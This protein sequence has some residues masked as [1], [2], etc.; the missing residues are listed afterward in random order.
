MLLKSNVSNSLSNGSMCFW[1][2]NDLLH[3]EEIKNQL[4]DFS[5]GRFSGVVIHARAGLRIEYLS[6]EWFDYFE[7]AVEQARQLGIDV[8]IY[9][10]D[11]WPSGFAGGKVNSLGKDYQSKTLFF[12]TEPEDAQNIL[13]AYRITDKGYIRIPSCEVKRGDLICAFKITP[14]YVDLLSYNV[15]KKFIEIT[16]E[17]Y[18]KRMGKYF[19]TV[20]KGVFTDEPQVSNLPYSPAIVNAWKEKY[21][22]DLLDDLY[23][24]A[25][26]DGEYKEFRVRYRKLISELLFNSFTSQISNW[27][28]QNNLLFTGHFATE[29]GLAQ[30]MSSNCGVMYQYTAMSMPGIDHLGKR[31]TSPILCKQVSSVA[32][33][34]GR[35]EILSETFGCSGWQINFNELYW[36][37]GRQNAL[38]ITKPCFHLSAYSMAGRRKRDYPAFFSY[39][40]PWWDE[41][42]KLMENIDGLSEFMKSGES[43]VDWLVISPLSSVMM[44]YKSQESIY[45]SAE[46]RKLVE[47]MLDAQL[48]CDLGDEKIISSLGRV[49]SGYFIVGNARYKN[50]VVSECEKLSED[51]ISLLE[52]F[53]L[54]GGIV[55]FINK[56]PLN[57]EYLN[58]TVICN[59]RE[60]L[61]KVAQKFSLD[62]VFEVCNASSGKIAHNLINR[63]RKTDNGYIT[64]IWSNED[65]AS[66]KYIVKYKCDNFGYTINTV[67][68]ATLERFTQKTYFDGK[69]VCA[70]I[71]LSS[72]A[73]LLLELVQGDIKVEDNVKTEEV[74]DASNIKV[75]LTDKNSITLDYASLSV[76]DG[77][78]GESKSVIHFINKIYNIRKHFDSSRDMNI[79]LKYSF[80]CDE[81]VNLTTL[82]LAVEDENVTDIFVCGQKLEKIRTSWWMDKKIGVYNIGD[83]VKYGQNEI[84]LSYNIPYTD[85]SLK[86]D[87]FESE[88]N[89][90]FFPVEPESIYIRGNF[91]VS[92]NNVLITPYEHIVD[93]KNFTLIPET[94]KT[95]GDLTVQNS[96]FYRGNAKYEFT[97][98]CDCKKDK[99]ILIRTE[100]AKCSCVTVEAN[101]Q[102]ITVINPDAYVDIT[103]ILS[104]GDN[105][106]TV[107]L[108]GTNRN[109][110]GPHHHIKGNPAM[111][112]PDTF[113]GVKGFED[114]VS[115]DVIT[116]NTWTESYNFIP[117]GCDRIKIKKLN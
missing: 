24:L 116:N 88:R 84:V 102:K 77:E 57:C 2:W 49:E 38:G 13:T 5:K 94:K 99:N 101:N 74:Y 61:Q 107:S 98:D 111:V 70:V 31:C 8:W 35:D 10:E 28:E 11:G 103:K 27:C 65:F 21:G 7:Y 50:L 97:V 19:G 36:L 112:G 34:L 4:I 95:L 25:V 44:N 58:G 72:C 68:P 76:E 92:V 32:N 115:P 47:N 43:C 55:W 82:E 90:F 109:L 15:V 9:D 60:L 78:F 86:K 17:E 113:M 45:Y 1:S 85:K 79:R 104:D 59:R 51:M 54:Q 117:F 40:E 29:D 71:E 75:S 52:C 48:D 16:H 67:N 53:V 63:T 62:R 108:I 96:W 110:L 83:L 30:Q 42:P 14:N 18:K 6:D 87:V 26:N 22:T 80:V 37:W 23:M 56:K 91:D 3:K 33:Q 64:Q 114:F 66:G 46:Y 41:F 100:N 20:I 81:G 105:C 39:Q 93:G 73:N 89:R 12:T 106:V 69:Y